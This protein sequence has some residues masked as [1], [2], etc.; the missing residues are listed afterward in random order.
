MTDID[1]FLFKVVVAAVIMVITTQYLWR[2][3]GFRMVVGSI[4]AMLAIECYPGTYHDKRERFYGLLVA[5]HDVE[6]RRKKEFGQ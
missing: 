5:W 3:E 1:W 2:R 4:F 6:K